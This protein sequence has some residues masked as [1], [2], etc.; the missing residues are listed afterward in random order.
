[1]HFLEKNVVF[2]TEDAY[3]TISVVDEADDKRTLYFGDGSKQ[4]QMLKNNP[5]RVLTP[6]EK[7]MA[8]WQLFVPQD[9]RNVLVLG[10]GGGSATK[11]CLQALPEAHISVVELRESVV[12]VARDYFALPNDD[13]LTVYLDDAA[14]FIANQAQDADKPF[15]LLLV[16][17]YDLENLYAYI[18]SEDFLNNCLKLLNVGGVV[19]LNLWGSHQT[20]FESVI[21]ALGKVFH[22]K[23]LVVPVVESSNVIVFAFHPETP[24][25]TFESLLKRIGHLE[26][27]FSV[28]WKT[29]L[30]TILQNNH[31]QLSLS[32]TL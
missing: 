21:A 3:G 17:M 2:S 18:Y 29:Y 27:D 15:D 5:D 32:I 4:S 11:H 13:R 22:W 10:L 26:K 8:C 6:Y 16:D 1:M 23:I 9:A 28:P 7:V 24:T 19:A 30:E 20:R 12:N 25:Y 14:Q 31:E